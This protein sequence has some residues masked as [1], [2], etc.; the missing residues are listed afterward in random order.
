MRAKVLNINYKDFFTKYILGLTKILCFISILFTVSCCKPSSK[1][2]SA[3]IKSSFEVKNV[4]QKKTHKMGDIRFSNIILFVKDI[5]VST[6]FYTNILKQEIEEDMGKGLSFKSG[7]GLWELENDDIILNKIG[8]NKIL[9]TR[10]PDFLIVFNMDGIDNIAITLKNSN[11]ELLHDVHE[12]SWGQKTIRFYDPDNHLIEVGE[13][14][15]S[16]TKRLHQ[17][18]MTLIEISNKTNLDITVIE[19]YLNE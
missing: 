10:N 16:V 18:G 1:R 12:E 13:T 2:H 3:K 15:Q 11:I 8:E 5:E 6:D 4:N 19:E 7:F 9:K 17:K 14:M